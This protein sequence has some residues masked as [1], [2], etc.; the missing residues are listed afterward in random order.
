[1]ITTL[2]FMYLNFSMAPWNLDDDV[3]NYFDW[4]L[5]NHLDFI[6]NVSSTNGNQY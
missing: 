3:L 1:M 4:C 6:R 2:F 5:S